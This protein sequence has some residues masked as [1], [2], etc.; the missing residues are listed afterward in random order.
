[1]CGTLAT[2][3]FGRS[4]SLS[5][6]RPGPLNPGSPCPH[7]GLDPESPEPPVA[8][9][10]SCASHRNICP[11]AEV[12]Y[13]ASG[14][15][16]CRFCNLDFGRIGVLIFASTSRQPLEGSRLRPRRR[17]EI[18]CQ[19]R[20]QLGG[21]LARSRFFYKRRFSASTERPEVPL[22]EAKK[23]ELLSFFVNNLYL[24]AHLSL[25]CLITRLTDTESGIPEGN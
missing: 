8:K 16:Q 1:M 23:R 17:G 22:N 6:G 2:W 9:T 13:V 3:S 10:A 15:A 18:P 24:Y 21:R 20:R 4:L 7:S 19:P 12:G 11:I 14:S 5:K 25:G